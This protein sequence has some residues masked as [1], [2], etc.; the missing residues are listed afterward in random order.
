[1]DM[2]NSPPTSPKVTVGIPFLNPGP[3]LEDAIRS[4]LAQTFTDWELLLV[5]DGSN[6][7]SLDI[8][9]RYASTDR[10][11]TLFDDGRNRG[12]VSRL[13]QIVSVARGLYIA[14]MD[15]DDMMHPERLAAQ[16]KLLDDNSNVDLV[17]SGAVYINQAR[18]PIGCSG[19]HSTGNVSLLDIIKTG[20]IIH[21]TVMSRKKWN[22]RFPYDPLFVRAEDRELFVRA[23]AQSNYLFDP[24]PLYFYNLEGNVRVKSWLASYGTTRVIL[25]HYGPGMIGRAWTAVL[26]AKE[27]IKT[28][29]L[30]VFVNLGFARWIARRRCLTLPAQQEYEMEQIISKLVA[31]SGLS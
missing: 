29:T 9:R 4:V 7:C 22:Q 21:P 13:N 31:P 1:M 24:R 30:P 23:F 20:A 6:D 18:R 14:R 16:N 17:H 8:A 19:T 5:N 10:R 27:M 3:L 26:W 15:A 11:I 12:L 28:M 25:S 2:H